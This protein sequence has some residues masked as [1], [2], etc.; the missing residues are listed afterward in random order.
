MI[1]RCTARPAILVDQ[2][3]GGTGDGV[4]HVH[5]MAQCPD[6]SCLSGAHLTVKGKE[7]FPGCL[8][9]EMP[10]SIMQSALVGNNDFHA[11]IM[12]NQSGSRETS[13]SSISCIEM[14]PCWN[15]SR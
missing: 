14:P 15:E 1:N 13:G 5:L 10:C 4:C 2:C 8:L 6:E 3:K 11:A 7:S 12:A 9:Q